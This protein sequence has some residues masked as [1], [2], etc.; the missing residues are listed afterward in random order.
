[1]IIAA[2]VIFSIQQAFVMHISSIATVFSVS[3]I[4][5]ILA[6]VSLVFFI[7]NINKITGND[8]VEPVKTHY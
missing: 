1:M 8:N 6:I 4:I 5:A 2:A 3:S 7:H